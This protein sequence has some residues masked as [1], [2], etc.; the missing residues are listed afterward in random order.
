MKTKKTKFCVLVSIFLFALSVLYPGIPPQDGKEKRQNSLIM[1]ELL[2]PAKKSLAPP[3]R[4]I[5]TRQ[6]ENSAINE[7]SPSG[8]FQSPAQTSGQKISPDQNKSAMEEARI[9]VQYIGYVKSEKKVVALIILEG[10][11]YA[12][13]SGDILEMGMTIGEI[14]PDDIEIIDQGSEPKRI[15]LEGEKP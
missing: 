4:N 12:V 6:R 11:T 3:K 1:K 13:E 7:F 2:I 9:N 8:D 15:N 14:T 10:Q 5:F